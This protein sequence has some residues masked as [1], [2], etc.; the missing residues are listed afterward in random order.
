MGRQVRRQLEGWEA[1][2]VGHGLRGILGIRR[3]WEVS[4]LLSMLLFIARGEQM[5]CG[6]LE[7]LVREG[8]VEV[9]V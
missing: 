3:V 9:E 8:R 4:A 2:V 5:V 1:V 6:G 7:G